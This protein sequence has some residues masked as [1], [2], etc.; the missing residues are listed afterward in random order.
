MPIKE[1]Q[2]VK[3]EQRIFGRNLVNSLL[4]GKLDKLTPDPLE[5]GFKSS[6]TELCYKF[7]LN[8][9]RKGQGYI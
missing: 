8:V 7:H 2:G 9:R 4:L 6:E 3:Q 1:F 5:L